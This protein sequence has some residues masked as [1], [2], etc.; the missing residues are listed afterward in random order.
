MSDEMVTVGFSWGV[1]RPDTRQ[2]KQQSIEL[3]PINLAVAIKVPAFMVLVRKHPD[4]DDE[5]IVL[6]PEGMRY[7]QEQIEK[8]FAEEQPATN[9]GWGDTPAR[10]FNKSETPAK[11]E[12]EVDEGWETTAAATVSKAEE[13]GWVETAGATAPASEDDEWGDA[14]TFKGDEGTK[15]SGN[16]PDTEVWNE[17]EEDWK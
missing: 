13:D 4:T 2:Y 6:T 14:P 8:L 11:V 1:L 17:N 15:I 7:A 9:E 16:E 12:S 3:T 10:L 5:I